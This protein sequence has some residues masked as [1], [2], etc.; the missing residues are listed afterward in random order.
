MRIY[1]LAGKFPL[2]PTKINHGIL[3]T[4]YYISRELINLG[5]EEYII[6][7]GQASLKNPPLKGINFQFVSRPYDIQSLLKI[8]DLWKTVPPTLVH[9]HGSDALSYAILKSIKAKDAPLVTHFHEVGKKAASMTVP[10]INDFKGFLKMSLW[11]YMRLPPREKFIA[12]VSDK[13]LAVSKQVAN[14]IV[15][16]YNISK[17]KI[18]VVYNGVEVEL[19][20]PKNKKE[21]KKLLGL[22]GKKVILYV[23]AFTFRKGI[24]Y[25]IEGFRLLLKMYKEPIVLLLIGGVPRWYRSHIY[26]A[27]LEK[28]TSDLKDKIIIKNAIPHH[29]LPFY[30]NS[31]DALVLPSIEEPFG[32]VALEA[33]SCKTPVVISKNT[34]VAEILTHKE[35]CLLI[36]PKDP[37]SLADSLYELLNN[38]MLSERIAEKGAIYVRENY[39]WRKVSERIL[40]IYQN[41]VH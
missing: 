28:W 7:H 10:P 29:S 24:N 21:S 31:A 8:I 32:K 20:T 3:P 34:G 23:G 5:L 2:N 33:L 15:R 19:F 6:C 22:S 40:R 16:I 30:Y 12:E 13:I 25:L 36:K 17:K 27:Y 26:W 39:N 4:L 9:G 11:Y 14:D 18:E 1:R 38:P 35:T 37:Y 41:T